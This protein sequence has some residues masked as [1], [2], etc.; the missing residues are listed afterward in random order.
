MKSKWLSALAALG[1][2]T[3]LSG[4]ARADS[5]EDRI[6]HRIK[7]DPTLDHSHVD[8][9][10]HDGRVILKGK[11][12]SEADAER[13]AQIAYEEGAKAVFDDLDIK[14]GD[15][16]EHSRVKRAY[17]DVVNGTKKA[18]RATGESTEDAYIHTKLKAKMM[19]SVEL[20][21]SD[22]DIDVHDNVAYLRGSVRTPEARE[23]ALEIA[24]HTDG[25]HRV[26]DELRVRGE[27]NIR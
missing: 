6:E 27:S 14:R 4:T 7:H 1:L 23:R 15:R 18:A 24:R 21:G 2:A 9:E 20:E 19:D 8:A 25:V 26:V 12:E 5:L 16:Y 22:I 10:V 3:A 17:H 13:A 11:V